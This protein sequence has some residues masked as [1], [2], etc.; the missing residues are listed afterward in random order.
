MSEIIARESQLLSTDHVV[1]LFELDASRWNGGTLRFTNE[2]DEDGN[3]L[4]FNG[5]TYQP[6]PVE[7]TGFEWTTQGKQPRPELKVTALDRDWMSLIIGADDLEGAQVTRIKTFRKCLDDGSDPDPLQTFPSQT[8]RIER[9]KEQSRTHIKFE[10][11][12]ALD[13]QGRQVPFRQCIR[14]TC[15]HTYRYWDG[16]KFVYEGVTCPYAGDRYYDLQGN[17][18]GD[19]AED[20]CPKD[21]NHGCK[22]RFGENGRLP[23]RGF[24]GLARTSTT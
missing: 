10:L 6:I 12:M 24:P 21:L 22:K 16:E 5:Y 20:V 4:Q 9:K 7:A 1:Q 18:V 19:P 11:T 14:D 8:Y 3:P 15:T 13:Q 2:T 17:E 23:F